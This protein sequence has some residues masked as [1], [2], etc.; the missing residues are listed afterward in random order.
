MM[1][2]SSSSTALHNKQGFK[3]D[4]EEE[5]RRGKGLTAHCI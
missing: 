5:R 1:D 3:E 4:G 2:I